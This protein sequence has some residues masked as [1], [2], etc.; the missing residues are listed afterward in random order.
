METKEITK[1]IVKGSLVKFYDCQQ[2]NNDRDFSGE[3]PKYYPIGKVINV[4]NYKSS[5]GYSDKVCD[6]Q[7]GDRVSKAHFVRCVEIIYNN[8]NQ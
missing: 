3:N 1:E 5:F 6:I 7:I 2:A 8:K 4:Y